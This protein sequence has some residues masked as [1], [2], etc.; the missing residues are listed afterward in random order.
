[1]FGD[2]YSTGAKPGCRSPRHGGGHRGGERHGFAYGPRGEFGGGPFGGGGPRGRGRRARRGDI[3]TAA[4]L[5]LAEEPRNGYQ[6]MQEVQERS[7]GVW[8]PSPGSVYPALQQLEDEGLIRTNES[9]GRKLFAITD[10]GRALLAERGA[11]RPAP[12]EQTGGAGG[13]HALGGLMREVASAFVQVMRTGSEGQIAKAAEVLAA[14]R[15][16]LYRILADGDVGAQS[17]GE[18]AGRPDTGADAGTVDQDS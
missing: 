4:L 3:R 13:A 9:D 1:M 7:G 15:R 17:G 2:A 16:D 11:D 18:A 12:W 14:T 6:I 8:S 10:D 5:L